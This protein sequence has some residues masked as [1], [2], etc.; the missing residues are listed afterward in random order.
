[1]NLLLDGIKNES[2][3]K[4]DQV[5]KLTV[6]GQTANYPVYRV[7]LDNLYFN[8]QND[9]IA[10]WISQYL[11]ENEDESLS[12]D[13][14]EHYNSV[15]HDFIYKSNPDRL[16]QT[17]N[18][19]KLLGQQKYG[20]VL[21]D[22]R[23]I[24]GNRRFTCLRNLSAEGE[25]YNYFETVILDKDYEHS[26]KQIK[27]LEL[28]IQIGSEE[29]VDYDPIDRLVGL[30]RDIEE[31]QLLTENEYARSTNQKITTV[32][33]DLEIAKLIVE[34]LDAIKSPGHYYLARELQ[35]DGPIRELY[36]ALKNVVDEDKKQELKYIAF[37]NLLMRP[38]EDMTR[39]IRNLKGIS[40]S[41]Y[42]DEFIGEEIDIAE[43]V[44]DSLPEDGK[45]NSETIR[46][47]RCDADIKEQ[48]KRTM[49]VVDAKVRVTETRNKPN[50][51]VKNAI[52][53][54]KSIDLEILKRL[55]EEQVGDLSTSLELL[56]EE[57][58][59]VKEAVECLKN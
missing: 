30:Y 58:R 54:I 24:D 40:K 49:D 37:T 33:K 6:D 14:K 13:N 11:S 36:A 39:F 21:K 50:Q 43:E 4:T 38:D 34:F 19:I 35:L 52:D 31:K 10:T 48:L 16:K 15:I 25:Q 2:V 5:V 7:R 18:N 23:I 57:M 22:G 27:M 17:Q 1:M 51:M 12:K 41:N 29:R 3:S 45:V 44:L 42:I 20:V 32:K 55:T 53:S 46:E 56:E 9:R 47:I 26:E 28:Q 8:D 59:K